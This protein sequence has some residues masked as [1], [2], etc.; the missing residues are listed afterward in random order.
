MS[1]HE[2]ADLGGDVSSVAPIAEDDGASIISGARHAR[3][4][5][6]GGDQPKASRAGRN[7]PA[8][9]AVGVALG[10]VIVASLLIYRA[11]FAVIVGLA[12]AYG[13][14]ELCRAISTLEARPAVLPLIAGGAAMQAAAW[15]RGPSGLTMALLATVCGVFVW[16]LADGAT[17]Y[18]RDA[19]ASTLVAVYVPLLA[20]FAV[21]LA[22]PHDGA[23]RVIVFV[24]TVVCSDTGGYASGVLFGK[25]P[26]APMVS[27]G[28]T[29]EGFAGSVI[30][31]SAAGA[32]FMAFTFHHVWWKGLL[33][34]L[35][36]AVTATIGDLGESMIKRD[37]GLKDMGRLLPGHGGIMDRLDSLLPCA[38]VAYLILSGFAPV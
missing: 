31:C 16:R 37:L 12:S 11:S 26:L 10:A 32:L 17:G 1:D 19:A 9:I 2:V 20:G 6:S 13:V 7:L 33:Y 21:L 3:H 35:A 15:V 24:A 23:A 5:R 18:L 14:Y 34:G 36:I 25:H 22:H 38:A 27:K 28:K 4:I 29:W 8:A 30:A